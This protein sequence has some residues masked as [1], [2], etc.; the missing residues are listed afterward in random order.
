M[1]YACGKY[2]VGFALQN[3]L[4]EVLDLAD[5]AA[6][7]N[8]NVH[9]ARHGSREGAVEP[10]AAAVAVHA[11]EQDL[12]RAAPRRLLRPLDGVDSRCLAAAV[13]IDLPLV[14]VVCPLLR[15][16]RTEDRLRAERSRCL[17]DELGVR[18]SGRVHRHLVGARRDHLAD[19]GDASKP[20]A[21]AIGQVQ[22]LG[23][24]AGK[25]DG[26]GAVVAR[27]RDVEEYD[28]V[29]ALLVIALRKFDRVARVAQV[30]EV[31]SLDDAPVLY[32]H[33]G[34]HSLG[35]HG[36]SFVA[37]AQ[38]ATPSSTVKVPSYT[39]RP[40]MTP[41]IEEAT[42]ASRSMSDTLAT[43]PLA[44]TG[45]PNA[46]AIWTYARTSSPVC[47]PSRAMSV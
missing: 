40:V 5:A 1:E 34:N 32:V 17:R 4:G 3:T 18:N 25:L 37:A 31:H 19:I 10:V 33:A 43:P 15:V 22:L 8:G 36:Y 23:C 30:H 28:L 6:R 9:C 2:G 41:S 44:I 45:C 35:K 7:D 29:G 13:D 27:R 11:R 14:G 47:M 26:G 20:A 42:S 39:A 12:A 24:A 16:D 46:F 38:A 21:D